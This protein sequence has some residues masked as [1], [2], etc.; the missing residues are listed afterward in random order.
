MKCM[1]VMLISAPP[2][3]ARCRQGRIQDFGKG[4][5]GGGGLGDG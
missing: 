4:G 3:L 1:Y 2:P 5:G